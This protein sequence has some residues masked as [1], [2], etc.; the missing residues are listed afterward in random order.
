MRS[1]GRVFYWYQTIADALVFFE[2]SAGL[3]APVLDAQGRLVGAL[4]ITDLLREW[5]DDEIAC[6]ERRA[7]E[8][9][10]LGSAPSRD[11]GRGRPLANRLA[12]AGS[13]R[14]KG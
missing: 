11:A 2:T 4:R 7:A 9:R 13:P 12:R 8:S 6:D 3:E 5:A 1:D 14:A 10:L